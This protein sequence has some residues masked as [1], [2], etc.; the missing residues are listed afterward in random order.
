M[1]TIKRRWIAIFLCMISLIV[2]LSTN[3]F[4]AEAIDV[5]KDVSLTIQYKYE[6]E[7]I[8]GAKFTVYKIAT[9]DTYGQ[10]K[11]TGDFAAYPVGFD[12]M[13]QDKWNELSET[14]A[15]YAKRDNLASVD[16]GKTDENGT[17]QLP[18]AG[19]TFKPG[20]Y[21]VVGETL[22]SG[23][24]IYT[25]KPSIVALP[26]IASG[27]TWSY[28][29]TIQPKY[30]REEDHALSR[31]VL[32]VWD[33]S[34]FETVRPSEVVIQLLKDGEVYDTVT[35][36]QANNWRHEWNDLDDRYTWNVVEKEMKGY[37][38]KVELNSSTFTVTNSYVV[39]V[40]SED[41]PVSKRII[42]DTPSSN[43][44][45]TFV[46]KANGDGYPIPKG[47]RNGIKEATVIGAGSTE[48]GR[49][50]FTEEGT[51]SYIISEKNTGAEG[52]TYDTD[53]YTLVFTVTLKT[54]NWISKTS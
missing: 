13:N 9:V 8:E 30:Q 2:V 18:S 32:K 34:G 5:N 21:L 29:L 17:L 41:P 49:M 23:G 33:D 28:T 40:I 7:G 16:S 36:N 27:N 51:Y 10:Y 50:E 1:K 15:G 44:T 4:A 43:E 26:M 52:Y 45:F 20:L 35:L 37:T 47:S 14:L 38:V 22:V 53:V 46:M 3:V 42:G 25:A 31:K 54:E 48:F 24:Y 19:K 39:P 12:S 11:L 6:E